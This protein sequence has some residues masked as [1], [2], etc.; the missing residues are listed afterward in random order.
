MHVGNAGSLPKAVTH[1]ALT[2]ECEH[3]WKAR[4]AGPALKGRVVGLTYPQC[5][6]PGKDGLA[7]DSSTL[8]H[9]RESQELT[10]QVD[11]AGPW[12]KTG[13]LQ[14]MVATNNCGH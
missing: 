9:D 5:S 3:G 8:G 14:F 12:V 1:Q 4:A 6:Y 10:R 7:C 13:G 11:K 2:A